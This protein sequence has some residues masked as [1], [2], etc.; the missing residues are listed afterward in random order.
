M[1][2]LLVTTTYALQVGYIDA[3]V[4]VYCMNF[5]MLLSVWVGTLGATRYIV[6]VMSIDNNLYNVQ[7]CTCIVRTPATIY[8]L[9]T[10][11][12][13]LSAI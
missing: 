13:M 4:Y 3:Q 6:V 8:I 2:C 9:T 10:N 5:L 7:H 1:R 12:G 11:V